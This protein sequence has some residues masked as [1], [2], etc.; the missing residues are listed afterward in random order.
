MAA[1][2]ASPEFLSWCCVQGALH[3][4][5]VFKET[6]R[7]CGLGGFATSDIAEGDLIIRVPQAIILTAASA[8]QSNSVARVLRVAADRGRTVSVEVLLFVHMVEQR[9]SCSYLRTLS[10]SF[11]P[12]AAAWGDELEQASGSN[13]HS[14]AMAM[15]QA[16]R[17]EH[18][19][20]KEAAPDL[21]IGMDAL[22]WAF[23]HYISRR[24]PSKL[25]STS[26]LELL[27]GCK[28]T[29]YFANHL[30]NLGAMVPLLDIL[31]H[32][33]ERQW[34]RL[35][36]SAN[37]RFLDVV[38]NY[39]VKAGDEILSNYGEGLSNEQLLFSFGFSQEANPHD[40]VAVRLGGG[41]CTYYIGQDAQGCAV[42]P[43]ALWEAMQRLL[44]E[45]E[46]DGGELAVGLCEAQ[47]LLSLMR[48]RLGALGGKRKR[49]RCEGAR[50]A[51]LRVYLEG[52]MRIMDA[53]VQLLEDIVDQCEEADD[54]EEVGEY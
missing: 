5:C 22:L 35:E 17:D 8:M 20:I 6:A 14:H 10:R 34:L 40:S 41:A 37:Q 13:L 45:E 27:K 25:T 42:V 51:H 46:E 33:G 38:C 43:R 15:L 23:S 54:G 19:F 12:C 47:A 50:E 24:Y 4:S 36:V 9:D 26:T 30:G 53:T 7:G 32:S 49:V 44:Y 2:A 21:P 11:L 48:T 39:P 52:Q 16:L 31:N 1:S 28:Q 29:D 3:P 18:D